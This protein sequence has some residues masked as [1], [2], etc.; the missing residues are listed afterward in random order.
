MT[1]ASVRMTEASETSQLQTEMWTDKQMEE[2]V[3]ELHSGGLAGYNQL[4]E[5]QLSH[6]CSPAGT[7]SWSL[8]MQP[9]LK[10]HA[11]SL[12]IWCVSSTTAVYIGFPDQ[13]IPV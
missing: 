13:L 1:A 7:S 9:V 4:S 11:R 6:L 10:S 2:L 12:F 5:S 3:L 8:S